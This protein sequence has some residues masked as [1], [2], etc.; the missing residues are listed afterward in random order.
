MPR[1]FDEFALLPI[2]TAADAASLRTLGRSKS[3]CR[4]ARRPTSPHQR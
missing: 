1:P 4:S 3:S 2:I